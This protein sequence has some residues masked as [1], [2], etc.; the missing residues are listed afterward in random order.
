MSDAREPIVIGI[1]GSPP[2][3]AALA[4]GLELAARR[5]APVRLAHAY[6]PSIYD[7]RAGG[8]YSD[9]GNGLREAMQRMMNAAEAQA[10]Q[11][12][13]GVQVSTRL[14][15]GSA[16]DAL[17]D[18]S[19]HADTVVLGTR[20]TGGFAD[21]V[22]GST[23]LHVATHAHAPV[24]A[25]P[26]P[27]EAEPTRHGVVVG[28]ETSP[29]AQSAIDYAFRYAA[30]TGEPLTALHT[31]TVPLPNGPAIRIPVM[32]DPDLT[33]ERKLAMLDETLAPWREKHPAVPVELKTLQSHATP[34]LV[35]AA[36][37]ARL[38]VVGC[39]GRGA[40]R[41]LLLGSV[42]HG[43]LHR[44]TSPVAI[45]HDHRPTA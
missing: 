24:V 31:W 18:E 25:V 3:E 16:V 39:R 10:R 1:D 34:A 21:L 26:V 44:A 40:L 38:V 20:G 42:S 35:A 2:S 37:E 17:V 22:I 19:G 13:P 33:A 15:A 41:S 9:F 23:T 45:V 30:E 4:W 11:A 6:E 28:V 8:Y 7:I 14:E 43:V 5:Q 32:P 27:G 12:Y 29:S 36:R